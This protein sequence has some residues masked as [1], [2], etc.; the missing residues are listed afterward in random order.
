MDTA[1]REMDQLLEGILKGI[2]G[3]LVGMVMKL[4]IS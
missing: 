2:V 3:Y 1:G 4:T